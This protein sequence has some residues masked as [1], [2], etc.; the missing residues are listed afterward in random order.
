MRAHA[1]CKINGNYVFA[2]MYSRCD[3]VLGFECRCGGVFCS[4]HR[5]SDKHACQFDYKEHG[6][7][8]IRKNNPV[9]VG[10]KVQKL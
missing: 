9:V 1:S 2:M 6:A 3:C 7:D 4:I 5:Y 10:Q 8:H